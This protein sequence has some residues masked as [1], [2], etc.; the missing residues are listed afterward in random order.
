MNIRVITTREARGTDA[1]ACFQFEGEKS[2][3]GPWQAV[4]P[5]IGEAVRRA[6]AAQS[7]DG[8]LRS[9][10]FA[11]SPGGRP[12]RIVVIGLGKRS[13]MNIEG[14]RRAA[15]ELPSRAKTLGL[16]RLTAVLP[17][18][19][20]VA[21]FDAAQAAAEGLGLATYAFRKYKKD[22]R[23]R[24]LAGAELVSDIAS[25][26]A[27]QDGAARGSLLARGACLARDLVNEPPSAK[28]PRALA[29]R[30]RS[31]AGRG[32]AVRIFDETACARMGMG[33]Y[34]A[35]ARGSAEPPRM[36]RLDYRPPKPRGHVVI[37]GK[38]VTFDSGGLDLKPSDGMRWMKDDM[39]GAAA[40]LG[41]FSILRDLRPAV[42]VTGIIGATENMPGGRAYKP[43]D[44][45]RA[46][47]GK[48]IEVDNTDA[49]G[50]LTLADMLTYASKEK[51]DA[52]IDLAT[53]TGACVVALGSSV[54]G[55]FTD[56]DALARELEGCSLRSGE[57]LWRLPLEPD[58]RDLNRSEVAAVKNSGGRWGG[59]ITAA[60]FLQEF[61]DRSIPW[62]HCDIAGP[63]F[64]ERPRAYTPFGGTGVMVRT[65]AEFLLGRS[66]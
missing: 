12:E 41:L 26:K 52:I 22:D 29:A 20:G 56:H 37:I 62:A 43:G 60:L 38:G 25:R 5:R 23:S 53:L 3:V 28:T 31:L 21:A 65:L 59:A 42:R 61:V 24:G 58:Y 27:A 1:L 17:L 33:A 11:V 45:L 35:V 66:R 30:A 48:T 7:F 15:G 6:A 2:P 54:T 34:L 10:L 19:A 64:T 32:V 63:A 14:V 36:I 9:L 46:M 49:E 47:N 55:L 4:S 8:K 39:S 13:A 16:R 18:G 57:K 51:P 50:R 44:V 40:V